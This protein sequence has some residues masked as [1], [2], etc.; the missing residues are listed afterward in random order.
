MRYFFD[1]PRACGCAG[2]H[3]GGRLPAC[4]CA[5]VHPRSRRELRPWFVLRLFDKRIE[6]GRRPRTNEL[7]G[8]YTDGETL[9]PIQNSEA[10]T[11]QADGSPYGRI[12][13]SRDNNRSSPGL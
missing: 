2:A 12:P 9:D 3:P 10:K 11:A 6:P 13:K 8:D 7:P 5:G 1:L 4:G